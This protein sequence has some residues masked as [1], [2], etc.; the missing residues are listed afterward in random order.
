MRTKNLTPPIERSRSKLFGKNIE[1]VL[2]LFKISKIYVLVNFSEF[3]YLI[4]A[5]FKVMFIRPNPPC[6]QALKIK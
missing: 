6:S 5:S 1:K 2:R 4:S 3:E